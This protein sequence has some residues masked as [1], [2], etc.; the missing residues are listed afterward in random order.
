MPCDDIG[1]IKVLPSSDT[2]LKSNM[3]E[4][5]IALNVSYTVLIAHSSFEKPHLNI[6]SCG[7]SVQFCSPFVQ[8]N[9]GLATGTPDIGNMLVGKADG[10]TAINSSLVLD[11]GRYTVIVHARWVHGAF[12]YDLAIGRLSVSIRKPS[13]SIDAWLI[14][15][16][17]VL[18][19]IAW[20]GVLR[21]MRRKPGTAVVAPEV[22]ADESDEM[23]E[24]WHAEARSVA[25]SI[26][27]A[28][29]ALVSYLGLG[30]LCF[31]LL[32]PSW[33]VIDAVYFCMVTCSTVGYGDLSP[34]N[35]SS[36]WFALLMIMI[37]I[38]LVFPVVG[39]ALSQ[40]VFAPITAKGRVLLDRIIPHRMIDATGDGIADYKVPRNAAFDYL[41]KLLPSFLLIVL[42]QLLSALA[43]SVIEGMDYFTAF[44]HCMVTATTV[45][46]GDTK[47]VSDEAK[48]FAVVHILIAVTL[49][50]ELGHTI[51]A[52]MHARRDLLLRDRLMKTRLTERRFKRLIG[53]A[54]LLREQDHR[55]DDSRG[56]ALDQKEFLLAMLMETGKVDQHD[57]MIFIRY[58]RRMDITQNGLI[59]LEDLE[60]MTRLDADGLRVT[61][62]VNRARAQGRS[63]QALGR[64]PT[65]RAIAHFASRMK[66]S[67]LAE[68]SVRSARRSAR[69][70]DSIRASTSPP[71][72]ARPTASPAPAP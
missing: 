30:S 60:S 31:R 20:L 48:T 61:E 9:A 4:A 62:A 50:A 67:G 56:E 66:P 70:E 33:S 14:I 5:G 58:F 53:H 69:S 26:A 63:L 22:S 10:L 68:Y 21:M 34:S 57:L 47:L 72:S 13:R 23:L 52:V 39:G 17:G 54:Q 15:L 12:K 32:E 28:G 64:S 7:S 45:G 65:M 44:Y 40:L 46:Y 42:V 38:A 1:T 25:I 59:D 29:F 41:T 11:E 18:L 27:S 2:M 19:G 6:H 51:A 43:L 71:S 35:N 24:A 36:R 8:T 49:L 16:L 55:E 37:G 3:I